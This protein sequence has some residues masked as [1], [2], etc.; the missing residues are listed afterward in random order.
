MPVFFPRTAGCFSWKFSSIFVFT[1]LVQASFTWSPH[2]FCLCV[3]LATPLLY[4][5]FLVTRLSFWMPPYVASFFHYKVS[6][7]H[8]TTTQ[9]KNSQRFSEPPN[10]SPWNWVVRT[11][12]SSYSTERFR[13]LLSSPPL[14]PSPLYHLSQSLSPPP[15]SSPELKAEHKRLADGV[16]LPGPWSLRK[17]ERRVLFL[18]C[19]LPFP[20]CISCAI[21]QPLHKFL[22]YL[23]S[24]SEATGSL[25]LEINRAILS[26][27]LN[28]W[29]QRSIST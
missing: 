24:P 4:A 19:F 26:S 6:F 18:F 5:L 7:Y 28:S 11:H 16:L 27:S 25:H 3:S 17:Y 12:L 13:S 2:T 8:V 29:E 15:P 14:S 9:T 21:V 22:S 1:T 20:R 23:S 10:W